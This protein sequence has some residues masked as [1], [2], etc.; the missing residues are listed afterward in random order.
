MGRG[1]G[2]EGLSLGDDIPP[3]GNPDYLLHMYLC[4]YIVGY[5][6]QIK[7]SVASLSWMHCSL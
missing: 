6:V 2:G 4:I 1:G 5:V 7:L 3:V